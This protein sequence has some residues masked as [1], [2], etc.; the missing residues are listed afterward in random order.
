MPDYDQRRTHISSSMVL[1]SRP[2]RAQRRAARLKLRRQKQVI[3][4]CCLGLLL[5]C[6]HFAFQTSPSVSD[7]PSEPSPSPIPNSQPTAKLLA[8]PQPEEVSTHLW[9]N[10]RI[11]AYCSCEQCC[12]HWAKSRPIDPDTGEEIVYGASSTPLIQGVSVAAPST[13]AF[14]TKITIPS[15]G[16]TVYVVQDRMAKYIEERY[17]GYTIDVYFADHEAALEWGYSIDE[18]CDVYIVGGES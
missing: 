15:I 13:L 3:T 1:K 12:G 18:W 9:G 17:N 2:S 16:D 5:G 8:T 14:G 11:T 4:V 7:I 6:A 10:A